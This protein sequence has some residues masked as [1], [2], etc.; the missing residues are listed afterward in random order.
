MGKIKVFVVDDSAIVRN[1]LTERLSKEPDIEVV[2]SALDPF[3]ARDKLENL[4]VDV[5]TLDIEMP[6]MDGIT[7]L[8]YLMKYA[9]TPVIIVSSLTDRTNQASMAA[10]NAGAVDIVPKPGGPMSIDEVVGVLSDKIRAAYRI[11]KSKLKGIVQTESD[12]LRKEPVKRKILSTITA[13]DKLIT[14]GASTGGT[15]AL[16]VLFKGFEIDFPPTL[17]V[18]HMPPKFTTTFAKRLNDVCDVTVRE[19][20][21]NERALAG[22]VYIAPGGYHMIIKTVGTDKI[23]KVVDG[24]KVFNQRPA[25]E[26]M[27]NSVAENI[28]KNAVGVLLTGMGRDGAKGLLNI[29]ESGGY[30]IAQDEASSIVWGMPKEAIDIGAACKVSGLTSISADIKKWLGK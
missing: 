12:D 6:R 23:I 7:F 20:V 27:F 10:L 16:E 3:V 24:P 2:G 25:V 9:P 30:T 13:T 17:A 4:N 26:L 1:I 19:A 8:K 15:Q 28:G 5:I 21:N 14:V 29:K 11:D 18:I 22:T